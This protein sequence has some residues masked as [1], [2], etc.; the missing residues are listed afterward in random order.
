MRVMAKPSRFAIDL[1]TRV[2]A[3]GS[4]VARCSET[5]TKNEGRMSGLVDSLKTFLNVVA[6]K[7]FKYC[8]TSAESC[9]MSRQ[10]RSSSYMAFG[11]ALGIFTFLVVLITRGS[12]AFAD[13][14]GDCGWVG[15][16]LRAS[17]SADADAAGAVA[18][19][20]TSCTSSFDE[21]VAASAL[22]SPATA[23]TA[24]SL[25]PL[26]AAAARLA[27]SLAR[28]FWAAAFDGSALSNPRRSAAAI[29][30]PPRVP[31]PS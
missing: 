29:A 16:E 11:A 18:P 10:T 8:A 2:A 27:L 23:G 9:L 5:A 31:S 13:L 12:W 30:S 17:S 19:S 25:P 22:T 24:A 26:G 14:R 1:S 15:L 7:S 20:P 21:D 28:S 6:L 4:S 3:A